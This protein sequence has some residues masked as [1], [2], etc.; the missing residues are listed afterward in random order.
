MKILL[1]FCAWFAA[2]FSCGAFAQSWILFVPAER[3]FRV[4]MPAVPTRPEPPPG[5]VEFRAA[6]GQ[7]TFSVFRHDPRRATDINRAR[8]YVEERLNDAGFSPSPVD[9]DSGNLGPDEME[10]RVGGSLNMHKVIVEAGRFYELVVQAPG[11]EGINRQEARDFF[12]SFQMGGVG[13]F[14]AFSNLPTPDTCQSR[15]NAFSRRFCE[16]LTCLLPGYES[17][18]VC[19]SLPPLLRN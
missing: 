2:L 1:T 17:H 11:D 15:S 14:P 12:N 19:A 7:R 13:L 4:L 5:S 16:Y 6:G 9:P 8:V 10:F 18:P 3:D